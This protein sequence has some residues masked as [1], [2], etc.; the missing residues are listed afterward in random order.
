MERTVRVDC[1]RL[2]KLARAANR[3]W[4][5]SI[6]CDDANEKA[7]RAGQPIDRD[8]IRRLTKHARGLDGWLKAIEKDAEHLWAACDVDYALIRWPTA[9]RYL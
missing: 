5:R 9:E 7:K 2:S 4:H 8:C 3:Q 1:D 6:A